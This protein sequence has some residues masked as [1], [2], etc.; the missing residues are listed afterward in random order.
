VT[1]EDARARSDHRRNCE[2][3]AIGDGAR[4][5]GPCGARHV[6]LED[7]PVPRRERPAV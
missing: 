7:V 5:S 4:D 1:V 6:M 2:I 3:D